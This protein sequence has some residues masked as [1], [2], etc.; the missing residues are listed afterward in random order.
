MSLL[1]LLFDD[2]YFYRP[3]HLLDQYFGR[4]LD[5]EELFQ[6][7]SI[8]DTSLFFPNLTSYYRPWRRRYS[9]PDISSDLKLDKDKFQVHIDV[10]KFSPEEIT[11]KVTD[12]NVITIEGKHDERKDEHGYISRQFVRKYAIPSCHDMK[13]IESKLSSD[14][15]LTITAPRNEEHRIVH[16]KI[17][18]CQTGVPSRHT[19]EKNVGKDNCND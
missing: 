3:F 18:I 15:V 16:R 11:V 13:Q 14:G 4:V 6:P 8:P 19:L 5:P 9:F 2:K 10:E 7:L 1:P 17:P 12:D